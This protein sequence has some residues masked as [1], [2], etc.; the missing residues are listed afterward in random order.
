[1]KLAA[2]PLVV[3]AALGLLGPAALMDD[4]RDDTSVV[5][6][7]TRSDASPDVPVATPVDLGRTIELIPVDDQL[8]LDDGSGAGESWTRLDDTGAEQQ[9][10]LDGATVH[11]TLRLDGDDLAL[12]T[13]V[14]RD[15]VTDVL[16]ATYRRDV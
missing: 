5:G 13:R 4:E 15:G 10:V 8:V 14:T 3:A 6:V 1:M 2:N 7:W 12:E 11:R 9:L 16:R